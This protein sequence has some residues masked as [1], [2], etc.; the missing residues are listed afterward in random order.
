[1]GVSIVVRMVKKK[2][3]RA[4][5]IK[6]LNSL[7]TLALTRVKSYTYVNHL[8]NSMGTSFLGHSR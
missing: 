8:F 6:P 3:E 1:M 4:A 5:K 7:T 2:E